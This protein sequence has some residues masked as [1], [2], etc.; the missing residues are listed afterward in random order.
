MISAHCEF[1]YFYILN[2][3]FCLF[4]KHLLGI[5]I[6]SLGL[7][8]HTL[9]SHLTPHTIDVSFSAFPGSFIYFHTHYVSHHWF[10]RTFGTWSACL[11]SKEITYIALAN[12]FCQV[13]IWSCHFSICLW[14]SMFSTGTS[15]LLIALCL[16]SF[17]C[18]PLLHSHTALN[19]T[20]S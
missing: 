17:I 13:Q 14:T 12:F 19:A 5:K 4:F 18:V 8:T 2:E 6:Y 20:V 10:T 1:F 7:S 9:Q 16:T 3:Y 11:P 15:F